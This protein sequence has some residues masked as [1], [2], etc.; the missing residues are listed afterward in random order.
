MIEEKKRVRGEGRGFRSLAKRDPKRMREI[1]SAG[2]K[3]A[4]ASGNAHRWTSKTAQAAGRKGGSTP[5]RR[6]RTDDRS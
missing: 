2:G 5:K 1:A 3:A 4:W 6:R